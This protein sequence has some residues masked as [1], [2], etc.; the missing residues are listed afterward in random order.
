MR[1]R[2]SRS[3][4]CAD[5]ILTA[6]EVPLRLWLED[7]AGSVSGGKCLP[8]RLAGTIQMCSQE[9]TTLPLVLSPLVF[10][11]AVCLASGFVTGRARG[12]ATGECEGFPGRSPLLPQRGT[13]GS[14]AAPAGAC[15]PLPA[16]FPLKVGRDQI[17]GPH[18]LTALAGGAASWGGWAN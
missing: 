10:T 11:A 16:V 8:C 6:G 4:G 5:R 18:A 3:A 17:C 7:R 14:W 12:G 1:S 13:S 2:R 15:T 9:T